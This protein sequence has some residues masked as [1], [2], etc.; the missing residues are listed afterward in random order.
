M[1]KR[2][3]DGKWEG[4]ARGDEKAMRDWGRGTMGEGQW[5]REVILGK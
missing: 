4:D 2:W 3:E 1:K 5:K